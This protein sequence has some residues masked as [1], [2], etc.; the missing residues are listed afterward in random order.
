MFEVGFTEIILIGLV[1]L[2]VV[3]PERLP[4]LVRTAGRWLG[5]AQRITRELRNEFDR[6]VGR[7]EFTRLQQDLRNTT[8]ERIGF[9]DQAPSAPLG[10]AP[11][12]GADT[13]G[14]GSA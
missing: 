6:D 4:E 1:A 11:T 5:R 9:N 7:S 10:S 2:L 14:S 12:S 8:S 3:G 13:Q